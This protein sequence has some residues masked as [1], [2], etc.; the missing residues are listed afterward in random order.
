MSVEPP[1]DTENPVLRAVQRQVQLL[2]YSQPDYIDDA[3]AIDDLISLTVRTRDGQTY[4][5][6]VPANEL[7]AAPN[8][9][10]Q[11]QASSE[12][13]NPLDFFHLTYACSQHLAYSFDPFL[14]FS[15]FGV[16]ALPH[17]LQAVYERMLPQAWLRFLF[18]DDPGEGKTIIAGLLLQQLKLRSVINDYIFLT[19]K[20]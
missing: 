9:A 18:A 1:L 2:E 16:Q 3:Q 14:A 17:Q 6:I 4:Q 7:A 15:M 10:L 12:L 20:Q 5:I 11:Q 8:Q 19:P 13:A